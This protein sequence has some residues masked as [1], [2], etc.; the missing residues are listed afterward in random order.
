MRHGGDPSGFSLPPDAWTR[1][2]ARPDDITPPT[3]QR[4]VGVARIRFKLAG[5]LTRMA[6]QAESGCLRVRSPRPEPGTA[7]AAVL[8]N[9]TGGL[10]DGDRIE[11]SAAWDAGTAAVVTTP[12]A[13]RIYRSRGEPA[14]IATR[15]NVA[16]NAL[17]LWLPQETILFDHGRLRRRT[18]VHIAEAGRLIACESLIFGRRAMGEVV[19][20]GSLL[21][22]WRIHYAGKLVFA[23][24]L[25][26]D[27]DIEATLDRPAI[28]NGAK[29]MATVILAGGATD[30]DLAAARKITG[31]LRSEAGVTRIGPVLV[32]RILAK[33][34]AAMRTDLTRL[35]QGLLGRI[36]IPAQDAGA[37]GEVTRLRL[38]RLWH[39]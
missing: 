8:I 28:A 38:P 14:H 33:D 29:A 16:A 39:F 27:G 7:R 1:T 4:S 36:E 9:T 2:G 32:A 31:K 30:E 35:L 17:A 26:L 37:A 24:T 6:E 22:A 10:T 25:K 15:L 3:L 21:D 12:A 20:D 34:G 5:G 11:V 13:E 18:D 19:R 23:D